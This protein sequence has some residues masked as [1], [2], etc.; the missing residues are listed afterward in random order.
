M[1]FSY[2]HEIDSEVH[3]CPK[4]DRLIVEL[5]EALAPNDSIQIQ[6][7]GNKEQTVFIKRA[8]ERVEIHSTHPIA[9][10]DADPCANCGE[11][12]ESSDAS[13]C[14]GCFA[15]PLLGE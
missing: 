7:Q 1:Q 8:T 12:V 3:N 6:L 4:I 15:E 5:G 2:V 13:I 9:A 10:L 11:M 14:F